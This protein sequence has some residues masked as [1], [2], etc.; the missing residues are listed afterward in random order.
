MSS[1][2]FDFII[3]E[4]PE[5]INK[6]IVTRLKVMAS[7]ITVEEALIINELLGLESEDVSQDS[8]NEKDLFEIGQESLGIKKAIQKFLDDA[9][10][11]IIVPRL[12]C[13]NRLTSPLNASGF[14]YI[15][16]RGKPHVVS[17]QQT[18]SYST[19]HNSCYKYILALSASNF[20][21]DFLQ[22]KA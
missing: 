18:Y 21:Q 15:N 1:D 6:D 10:T 3:L 19:R 7:E 13:E 17:G 22:D 11:K 14:S 4:I 12:H 5:N 2:K 8:L 16:I 9:I 20:L